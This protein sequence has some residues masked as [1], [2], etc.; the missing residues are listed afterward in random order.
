M[1][2]YGATPFLDVISDH[3]VRV[4]DLAGQLGR[5]IMSRIATCVEA[6]HGS[7]AKERP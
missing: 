5:R 3:G 4:H 6:T 1:N 7:R 2:R